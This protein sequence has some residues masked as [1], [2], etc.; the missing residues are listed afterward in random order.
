MTGHDFWR[1]RWERGEIGWHRDQ[2]QSRLVEFFV[3]VAP[4]P[5]RVLV[6]LCGKTLDLVWLH[7]Q[8]H[9]VVGV[10]LSELACRA[11]FEERGLS[12]TERRVGA[13]QVFEAPGYQLFQGDFFVMTAE[14]LGPI[15]VIYDRAALIAL[16]IDQ[17]VLYAQKIR[18]LSSTLSLG[19]GKQAPILGITLERVPAD[20][21]GPPFC[22]KAEEVQ[23]LYQG[24]GQ[25]ELLA[26]DDL[27]EKSPSGASVREWTYRVF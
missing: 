3:Q 9:D 13:F 17:R 21:N 15:G 24:F 1:G 18:E 4:H 2:P 8:G 26:L 11:F 16:P 5:T 23:G 25:F 14:V 20:S 27:P 19:D 7:E 12:P 6:P 10:E 22:V